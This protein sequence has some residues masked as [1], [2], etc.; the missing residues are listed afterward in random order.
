VGLWRASRRPGVSAVVRSPASWVLAAGAATLLAVLGGLRVVRAVRIRLSRAP[1]RPPRDRLGPSAIVFHGSTPPQNTLAGPPPAAPQRGEGGLPPLAGAATEVLDVLA[2]LVDTRDHRYA[3]T[4]A[5][6]TTYRDT[7][8]AALS[9][10][11]GPYWME[12]SFGAV[13]VALTMGPEMLSLAGAFDDYFNRDYVAASLETLGLAGGWPRTYDG[14][15]TATLHV[16]DSH[17]R[18]VDVVL[19]PSG[20][21]ADAAQLSAALQTTID[22]VPS[23]PAD[24]VACTAAGGEVRFEL[25]QT[26]VREGSFIRVRS[27]SSL[28][29]LG[30]DGPLEP[31]GDTAAVAS[32]TGK[33]VPG[34]FPLALDG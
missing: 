1:E 24:W 18:N 14:T 20:S 6:L 11:L 21:F 12:T 19:A 32:L 7:Q 30:L 31:P 15:A 3:G 26:E 9:A 13:D 10:Q 22:A 28:A 27:G 5:D 25:A 34:G 23:V 33:P 8:H 17:D 4:A 2:L 29:A 16:R